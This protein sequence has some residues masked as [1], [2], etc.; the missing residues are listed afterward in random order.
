MASA[1]AV[2]SGTSKETERVIE[3]LNYKFHWV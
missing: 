2:Y 3:L 1:L